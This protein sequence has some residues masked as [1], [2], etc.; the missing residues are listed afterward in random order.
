MYL[1][2]NRPGFLYKL[3]HNVAVILFDRTNVS[4]GGESDAAS[5]PNGPGLSSGRCTRRGGRPRRGSAATRACGSYLRS[6]QQKKKKEEFF[7][8]KR[9][10]TA[11]KEFAAGKLVVP[12]V[13]ADPTCFIFICVNAAMQVSPFPRFSTGFIRCYVHFSDTR[14]PLSN[15]MAGFRF[16]GS[17]EL[18]S[19]RCL[20]LLF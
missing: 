1:F 6:D 3:P 20:I 11:C 5:P 4:L 17:S 13:H 7:P 9:C 8:P 14:G 18:L 2:P 16:P 15:A 12:R 19:S 10:E